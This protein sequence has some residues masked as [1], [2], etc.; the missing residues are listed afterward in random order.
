MRKTILTITL[1]LFTLFTFG[2]ENKYV[3]TEVL[4]VRSGA[5]TNNEI[6]DKISKGEKVTIL[7]ISNNWSEV[8]LENGNVGYVSSKFLSSSNPNEKGG[9]SFLYIIGGLIALTVLYQLFKG[10]SNSNSSSTK[11][12]SSKIPEQQQKQKYYCKC[13]GADFKSIRDLTFNSCSKSSTK[14]HELFEGGVAN[15]YHCKDCGQDFKSLK[16]L[17]FNSCSKSP[18]RKHRPYEGSIK[19]RYTCKHCGQQ[20]KNLK[21]LTFNSCSKSPSRKHQPAK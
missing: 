4:N 2:Q 5:S 7:S 10:G 17:T 15:K 12:I 16:D 20:F 21:D 18:T 14:K 8:E 3:N 1:L 6:V 19:S 9:F 11:S 13:C